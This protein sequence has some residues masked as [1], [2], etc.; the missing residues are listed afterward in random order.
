M[1]IKVQTAR[2]VRKSRTVAKK[3][4]VKKATG[5]KP[6]ELFALQLRMGQVPKPDQEL[7][8]HDVRRWRSRGSLGQT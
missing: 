4:V 8:F 3:P 7:R 5:S 2:T 6:S 1:P